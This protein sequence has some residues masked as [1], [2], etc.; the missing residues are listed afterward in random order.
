MI[1]LRSDTVTK[2]SAEMLEAMVNADLGDDVFGEDP[3]V[4]Q[5]EAELAQRFGMEAGLFCPSGTMTN[6]IAV[7]THTVPGDEVI[8]DFNCHVNFYEQG[9]MARNASVSV[10]PIFGNR[11]V[12]TAND[13]KAKLRPVDDH[14]PTT[15]LV[16][17]E[18]TCNRGGGKVFPLENIKEIRALCDSTGLKL[19][20][21]GARIFNA[22]VA[23]GVDAK[24]YGDHFDSISICL[25]KGLGCP[26]G[27]VLLGNRSFINKARRVRKVLGGGMRQAGIIAAAGIYAINNNVD[28]LSVDHARA[29]EIGQLLYGLAFVD[30]VLE[31]ETNILV[32]KVKEEFDADKIAAQLEQAGIGCFTVGENRI[33][34]VFHLDVSEGAYSEMKKR[35]KA[36]SPVELQG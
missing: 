1:D 16:L 26:I 30:S 6:Q 27:S 24:T 31:P 25:S 3:T 8:C 18:N 29:K 34:F 14:F 28:R 33:R 36:F 2:P 15:K 22:I 12:F 4:A 20:L 5:L 7:M 11:G 13:V 23:S 17:V 9:G 10:N 32:F 35:V 21:D 19:H